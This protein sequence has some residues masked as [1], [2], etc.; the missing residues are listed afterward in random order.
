MKRIILT[1][2]VFWIVTGLLLGICAG[3]AAEFPYPKVAFSADMTMK[4]KA[5]GSNQPHTIQGKVYS[6][7]G[8]ERREIS[9]GGRTVAIIKERDK[10]GTVTLM[11]GQ[12]MFMKNQDPQSSKDPETMIREGELKLTRQGSEKIDGYAT[13]KYKIES[14]QKGK[15]SFSGYAW[16]TS[17][18]I[19]I[20][21]KGTAIDNGIRQEV[22]VNYTNII[23]AKQNPN[24]FAIPGDYRE[25][26]TGLGG[27]G[28]M[29]SGT[30]GMTPEQM[31][32]LKEM[33]ENQNRQ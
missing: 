7:E 33:M 13:T 22:E 26:P 27:M 9:S 20:R 17:Q 15:D 3:T 5:A 25:I 30:Q 8:K 32:Q 16:F 1:S 31:K 18:N 21:F 24:L 11:P 4:L 19:P 28:G 12:K 29:G 23:I 10:D 14:T 2:A 6:A